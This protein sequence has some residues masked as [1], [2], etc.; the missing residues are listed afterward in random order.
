M[1]ND[2]LPVDII[3]SGAEAPLLGPSWVIT[4]T[5]DHKSNVTLAL[6]DDTNVSRSM[7]IIDAY[8]LC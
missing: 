3:H 4:R 8:R 5:Y 2:Q 6:P 1:Q 7:D